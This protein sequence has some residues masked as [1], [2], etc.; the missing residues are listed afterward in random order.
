MGCPQPSLEFLLFSTVPTLESFGLSR[1]NSVA[2]M[3][4]RLHDLVEQWMHASMEAHLAQWL[5]TRRNLTGSTGT[6]NRG[7]SEIG[8]SL[9]QGDVNESGEPVRHKLPT[10]ACCPSPDLDLPHLSP[11][12]LSAAS[13][14]CAA[15]S[16]PGEQQAYRA[17]LRSRRTDRLQT[18]ATIRPDSQSVPSANKPPSPQ[19]HTHPRGPGERILLARAFSP[20]QESRVHYRGNRVGFL[21]P[22]A[23]A[24]DPIPNSKFS[25][26]AASDES[27]HLFAA[28]RNATLNFCSIVC[29]PQ[30]NSFHRKE[31][32][33]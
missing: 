4:G 20:V 6:S 21:R 13:L 3:R 26:T 28:A 24:R 25:R 9:P 33:L 1:L 19:P 29:Y 18:S 22:V 23:I 11:P 14:V 12:L 2:N 16:H 32:A 5:L 10:F 15:L 27:T 7:Q 17:T 8:H 30:M 31:A